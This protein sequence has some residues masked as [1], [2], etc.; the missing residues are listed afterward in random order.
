MT[1]DSTPSSKVHFDILYLKTKNGQISF[2][3]SEIS[4]VFLMCFGG[5]QY[6]IQMKW[7]FRN[8]LFI[9]MVMTSTHKLNEIC[10]FNLFTKTKPLLV[11]KLKPLAYNIKNESILNNL[12][13]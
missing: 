4:F 7:N 9:Y 13:S 6:R 1:Y 3:F 10:I 12:E 2:V 5:C 8:L 11:K